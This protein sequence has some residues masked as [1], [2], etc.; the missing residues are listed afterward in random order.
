MDLSCVWQCLNGD[1]GR[2]A[3]TFH[4]RAVVTLGTGFASIT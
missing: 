4:G 1:F 3:I 2:D